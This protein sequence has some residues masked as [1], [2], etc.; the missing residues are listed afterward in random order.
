MKLICVLAKDGNRPL[1]FPYFRYMRL[2]LH[3]FLRLIPELQETSLTAEGMRPASP[4]D[5]LKRTRYSASSCPE[6]SSFRCESLWF[7]FHTS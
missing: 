6:G 7:L 3:I 2:Y 4:E 5:D 1:C